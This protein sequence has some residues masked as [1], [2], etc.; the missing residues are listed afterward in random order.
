MSRDVRD[1]TRNDVEAMLRQA[2]AQDAP[3][4]DPAFADALETRLR[5]VHQTLAAAPA[6][7]A[8]QAP[9]RRPRRGGLVPTGRELLARLGTVAV[10][11][12]VVAA[13]LVAG[14]W[15]LAPVT[16]A[17]P[18]PAA[19]L[20]DAVNVAVTLP[21]GT[22]LE[23]PDGLILP[24]GAVVSVGPGGS[25]RIGDEILRP[26]DSA[27]V[28]QGHVTVT[29]ASGPPPTS[30]PRLSSPTATASAQPSTSPAP[31]GTAVDDGTGPGA[32]ATPVPSEASPSQTTTV[33]PRSTQPSATGDPSAAPT[34]TPLVLRPRL[35]VALITGPRLAV[36]WSQTYG[37]DH[38]VLLVTRSRGASA[39]DPVYP[40]GMVLAEFAAPPDPRLRIRIPDG[41]TEV[42]LMVVALRADGS[43]IRRSAIVTVAIPAPASPSAPASLGPEPT[44]VPSPSPTPAG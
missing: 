8:A 38:Y 32:S 30:S 29:R 17:T 5:A 16:P 41:V 13:V 12:A 44:P 7:P 21:D 37:A 15:R 39:A 10:T 19:Q 2:G 34:A 42:R 11:L 31:T 3:A 23:D 28:E 14:P 36:T 20:D 40:G 33:T 26:G 22:V 24:L 18:A 35:R 9:E 43:I 4:P 25:A 27:V 1:Y 6:A